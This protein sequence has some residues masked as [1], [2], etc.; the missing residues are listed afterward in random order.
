MLWI[1]DVEMVDTLDE[2]KSSRSVNGRDFDKFEMPDAKIA[3]ALNNIIQNSQ[4]QKK[5]SLEEQKAQKK[6]WFLRGR[7]IAFMI[8]DDFRV[9]GAHDAVLDHADLFCYSS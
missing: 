2:L 4:I 8:Y 1:K 7:H 6:D 3:S 5:V 9:T